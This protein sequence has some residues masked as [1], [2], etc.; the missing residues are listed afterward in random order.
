MSNDNADLISRPLSFR[1]SRNAAPVLSAPVIVEAVGGVLDPTQVTN[2]ATV[3]IDENAQLK[4]GDT[5]VLE[6]QGK[7]GEGSATLRETAQADGEF[8]LT[9][10]YALV[11]ANEG[12]SVTL[13]YTI[14][15]A[16][17]GDPEGPS[18]ASTYSVKSNL[19][20][21][22]LKV[23]GAR[24]NPGTYRASGM[25]RWLMAFDSTTGQPLLAQWQYAGDAT[26]S[27]ATAAWLDTKPDRLLRV[28]TA[29]DL[30]TLNT[31]NLVGNGIDMTITGQAAFTAHR[32]TGDVVVWGNPGY[33]GGAL[34]AIGTMTDISELSCTGS[35][36]VARTHSGQ[37]VAWGAPTQG[38]VTPFP[39]RTYV[40]VCGNSIA[41]TALNDQGKV[42][43][44]GVNAA[45][46]L[47]PEPIKALTDISQVIAAGT[48]FA[49]LRK[50]GTVVAWGAPTLGG[51]V[52]PP[53]DGFNDVIEV[54]GNNQAFA[55]LHGQ[56]RVVGWGLPAAG[57]TVPDAI[58]ALTDV[59]ELSCAN[60]QA[61]ALRHGTTGGGI[62][63]KTWGNQAYGGVVDPIIG[64]FNDI[65]AVVST[66]Q[67][68]AA[69]RGNGRVNKVVAWGGTAGTGGV[70]PDAV[71]DLDDVVQIAGSSKAFAALRRNG[72]V[73]AWG[74]TTVGGAISAEVKAKLKD[75]LAIYSNSHGFAALT[76]DNQV[77]SWGH[78]TGGGDSSAVD[79]RLQGKLS[80]YATPT[81]AGIAERARSLL[82]R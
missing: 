22:T 27:E 7:D 15:R 16:A 1:V 5:V 42:I 18:A 56:N 66:W 62:F 78:A 9:A 69:L 54:I 13:E 25:S 37:V 21:G 43:A 10:P 31:A 8:D 46:A 28:Q 38:G 79:A 70:V 32:N 41:F 51:T 48:A 53:I 67:S 50:N 3:R 29:T 44:W 76:A 82:A 49:A 60:A 47:V 35:A 12:G 23:M 64:G 11:L 39:G 33:G 63:V 4:R 71:G 52:T 2:G 14:E 34:G 65:L 58:A 30:V 55:A 81:S 68:F 57:G 61:F 6:W 24:W 75:V 19:Q 74:D 59:V 77:V 17:G 72:E 26:W 45:G 73:V 20:P 80:Y 36:F 40:Q